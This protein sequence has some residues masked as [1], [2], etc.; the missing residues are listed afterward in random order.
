ML[1]EIYSMK[2][3]MNLIAEWRR[4]CC[5]GSFH[6]PSFGRN[7]YLICNVF[8]WN[9]HDCDNTD[10]VDSITVWIWLLIV[11]TKLKRSCNRIFINN[12]I[13]IWIY[14]SNTS[15]IIF[16]IKRKLLKIKRI[17]ENEKRKGCVSLDD[18]GMCNFSA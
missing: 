7:R 3:L 1:Y 8:Y 17:T 12:K 16:L 13:Y 9:L 14:V 6:W 5:V 18:P 4:C 11:S 15:T 10:Y 2:I